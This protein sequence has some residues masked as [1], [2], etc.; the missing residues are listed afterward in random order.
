[1][2]DLEA[3]PMEEI[4]DTYESGYNPSLHAFS[5]HNWTLEKINHFCYQQDL[6]KESEEP[7]K[8]RAK[9]D[10][11]KS[12]RKQTNPRRVDL[13]KKKYITDAA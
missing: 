3:V 12:K 11:S 13:V 2:D 5:L 7:Q 4:I 8:K 9:T 1:M 6:V 10:G